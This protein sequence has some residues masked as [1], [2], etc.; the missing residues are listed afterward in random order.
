MLNRIGGDRLVTVSG[1][2]TL[3]MISAEGYRR[4]FV[5]GA[6]VDVATGTVQSPSEE[7]MT[8]SG[9]NEESEWLEA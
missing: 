8:D 1:P 7:I 4:V 5:N 9:N 6:S 2:V 3:D